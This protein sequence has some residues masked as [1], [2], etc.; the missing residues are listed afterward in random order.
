MVIVFLAFLVF[1]HLKFIH[2]LKKCHNRMKLISYLTYK[3]EFNYL[4]DWCQL[5]ESNNKL[6]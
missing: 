2:L 1:F 5:D 3:N 4:Y 6:Y